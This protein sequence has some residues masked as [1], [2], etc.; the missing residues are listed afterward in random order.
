MAGLRPYAPTETADVSRKNS[1]WA[2]LD[3]AVKDVP[4]HEQLFVLIDANARTGKRG[5]GGVGSKDNE[6]L[7]D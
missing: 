4:T 3:S 7:G 5:E 2:S 1:F 6:V